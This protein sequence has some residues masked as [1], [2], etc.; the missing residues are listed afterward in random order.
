[1]FLLA[2]RTPTSPAP[3]ALLIRAR[4]LVPKHGLV[5]GSTD[6]GDL[7]F[8]RPWNAPSVRVGDHTAR[9]PVNAAASAKMYRIHRAGWATGLACVVNL[10]SACRSKAGETGLSSQMPAKRSS[11]T[12]RLYTECKTLGS[13]RT[14][15]SNHEVPVGYSAAGRSPG[16]HGRNH[17]IHLVHTH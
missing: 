7:L 12:L 17:E 4:Q 10:P 3:V 9:E 13:H 16:R 15:H 1:M 5:S 8:M 2:G 6:D 14:P 11:P